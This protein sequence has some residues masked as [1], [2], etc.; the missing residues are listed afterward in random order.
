M[1]LHFY[2][3]R[4]VLFVIPLLIGITLVAFV[5]ANAVPVDPI[6]VNLGQR[7]MSD[8]TVVKAF[9]EEWGLDKSPV[10]QYLTYLVN[11]LHGN[12]GRSIKSRRAVAD[13]IRQYLPATI[14]LATTSIVAGVLMGVAFGIIAAV[15]RGRLLDYVT[16]T[17]AL[18]GVSFPVFVLALL[19]LAVLHV[20]LGWV[21]GPGRLDFTMQPPPNVTGLFTIDS[22]LAGDWAKF[23]SSI[24]HLILPS[25]IL[26]LFSSGLIARITR[27]S[28]LEVLGAEY[29]RT[30]RAKGLTEFSVIL[31]HA[32]GNALIPVVTIIGLSYGNF[33][34]GAV[35]TERIFSWP[36]IGQ[37]AFGAAT[38]QDF[39]AIMGVTMLI[40]FIYVGVNFVVDLLYFFIDPRI[41]AT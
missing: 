21:S 27:S 9:R 15:W 10:E 14:E 35:L 33:L 38:T 11:L 41:R 40:A 32:L 25:L 8:P 2:I 36:G 31:R 29:V 5:I 23:S 20:K 7:A 17:I 22:L 12:L 6:S 3:L 39:P 37:Y 28:M 4:R 1:P 30:A 34:S 16:R 13:D 19:G 24:S 18:L 26:G